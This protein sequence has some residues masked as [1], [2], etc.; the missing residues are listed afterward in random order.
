MINKHLHSQLSKFHAGWLSLNGWKKFLSDRDVDGL[1]SEIDI[2]RLRSKCK[3][4]Y[5]AVDCILKEYHRNTLMKCLQ[6]AIDKINSFELSEEL[7]DFEEDEVYPV[8]TNGPKNLAKWYCTYNL[9]GFFVNCKNPN[10]RVV[11]PPFFNNN[12]DIKSAILHYCKDNLAALSCESLHEYIHVTCLPN[13]L[14]QRKS[15]TKNNQMT[16]NEILEENG[17]CNICIRTV[18]TWMN[19]LG[20]SFSDRKKTIITTS[21]RVRRIL[22]IEIIS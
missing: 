8:K 2:F 14:K 17:L 1:Y 7:E 16:I 20:F 18:N 5:F 11:L 12:P 21:M 4:L 10:G 19:L 3:Y 13:L 22:F 9:N 15:E 6:M